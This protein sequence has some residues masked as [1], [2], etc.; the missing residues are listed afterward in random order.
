MTTEIAAHAAA[1][2]E[3]GGRCRRS[4]L[5]RRRSV[6]MALLHGSF[7]QR[8]RRIRRASDRHFAAIDWHHPQWLAVS[9]LILLLCAGDAFMTLTLISLGAEEVN[10]IMK[11][12]VLGSG[13]SFALWKM[14]LTSG[15]V[16]VLTVLAQLRAFG[17]MP[18]GLLLYAV[19]AGYIVLIGYEFWLLDHI[20]QGAFV[21]PT[22]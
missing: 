17:W 21:A 20:L 3:F 2:G 18:I 5:D 16:V 19:L 8:R 12:L 4:G 15:G 9:M 11:P 7:K 14:G 1:T 6:F 13:P 10:P 22:A